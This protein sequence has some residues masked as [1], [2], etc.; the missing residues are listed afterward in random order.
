MPAESR[1]DP[2]RSRSGRILSKDRVVATWLN[3]QDG[4]H[5]HDNEFRLT[6]VGS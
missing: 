6:R 5:V 1:G 3:Y 4:R 2:V